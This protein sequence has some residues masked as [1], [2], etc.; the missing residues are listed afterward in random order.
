M[1]SFPIWTQSADFTYT[2]V[3][4]ENSTRREWTETFHAAAFSEEKARSL[5]KQLY[6]KKVEENQALTDFESSLNDDFSETDRKKT[7]MKPKV[8]SLMTDQK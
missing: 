5:I 6:D 7:S 8:Y 3:E 2:H 4:D 1:K